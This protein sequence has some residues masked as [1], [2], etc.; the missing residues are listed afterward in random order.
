MLNKAQLIG[1]VGQAPEI[2]DA[3]TGQVATLSLATSEKWKDKNTGE[4]KEATEWPRLV[5]WG[6]LVNVVQNYVNKGDRLY[7][8]GRIQTRTWET[9]AGEKRYTTEVNVRELKMLT[10]KSQSGAAAPP[11]PAAPA[12]GAL[13]AD[14]DQDLPF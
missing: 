11:P 2:R 10:P 4:T 6:P 13:P 5:V 3:G 14:V 12:Y 8:E 9:D 7:I 1:N